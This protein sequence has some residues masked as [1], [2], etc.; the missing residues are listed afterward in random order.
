MEN[1]ATLTTGP[2]G[3]TL[4]SLT[5]PMVF[6]IFAIVAFNLVDTYFVGKLGTQ[7]LAA[8]GFILPVVMFVGSI[9]LGLGIGT[10]AVVS[11]AIGEGNHE[12]VIRLSTDSLVLAVLIVAFFVV[13]G[14]L[15][16]DP[17]FT[18][19]GATPELLPLIREYMT[20]WYVGMIFVVVPMVGNNV[21]RASGDTLTPGIIMCVAAVVNTV[22]D[23]IL[24][25]GWAGMPALKLKGA[26][27]A[28]VFAR[29]TTL[30]LSLSI[31]HFR[32]RMLSFALPRLA[33]LW[34]SWK[35]V[36]Y[37]AIPTAATNVLMPLS[38]GIITRLASQFG[39]SAVA[40]V[41]VGAKI[42]AFALLLIIAL[43]SVL[44][45]FVGQNWGAQKSDRVLLAQ[46]H[47]YRFSFC[48]GLFAMAVLI[49]AAA[50]IA[51]LFSK[52]PEVVSNIVLYLRIVP[53][54]YGLLG[55]SFL[56]VTV[57]NAVNRP[58]T[59][60]GINLSRV[61]LLFVPLAIA[62]ARIFGFKGLLCGITVANIVAGCGALLWIHTSLNEEMKLG[63]SLPAGKSAIG[64]P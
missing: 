53:L 61:F 30:T 23:P 17:L 56:V 15:T 48:W 5:A 42:D 39:D 49:V 27:L 54:S 36:L 28:T 8:M 34:E 32:K 29:A 47:S 4:I 59:A 55:I 41:G 40:A 57:F 45:P 58:F 51:R 52:Q 3:R 43:R 11:R 20:I 37:I 14:L 9:A 62:G 25:F 26:A 44:V 21:L 1:K 13:I 31:L 22:L 2:I 35:R 60:A 7:Y 33:H 12:R 6:G 46:R 63:S 38:M 16:I 19:L 18:A 24:I 10:S 64:G 50:P